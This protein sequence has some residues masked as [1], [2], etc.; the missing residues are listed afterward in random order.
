MG[1]GSGGA[2]QHGGQGSPAA[3]RR[4]AGA[5]GPAQKQPAACA[6]GT[7]RQ[8]R[9]RGGVPTAVVPESS[10]REVMKGEE[11]TRMLTAGFNRAEKG[12]KTRIDGGAEL[13]RP[14]MAA[15]AAQAKSAGVGA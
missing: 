2:G 13:R 3:P 14:T 11:S 9:Q 5:P 4:T 12:R 10:G 6:G 7:A 1:K 15:A 8:L